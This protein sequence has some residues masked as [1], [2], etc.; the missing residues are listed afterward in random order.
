MHAFLFDPFT[1]KWKEPAI[2]RRG[3]GKKK[4]GEKGGERGRKG[5]SVDMMFRM[6][7]IRRAEDVC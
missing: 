4:K 2:V 6:I 7:G 1:W 3:S 5:G